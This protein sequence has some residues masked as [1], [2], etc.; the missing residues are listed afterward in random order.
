[1]GKKPEQPRGLDPKS[2][3][4]AMARM[5]LSIRMAANHFSNLFDG[6]NDPATDIQEEVSKFMRMPGG[7]V[8]QITAGVEYQTVLHMQALMFLLS[9]SIVNIALSSR[10]LHNAGA[11]LT[12]TQTDLAR[13]LATYVANLIEQMVTTAYAQHSAEKQLGDVLARKDDDA[14]SN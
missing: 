7:K 5:Q 3:I 13:G 9:E 4:E 14:A 12:L 6:M 2:S 11:N 1:M 8:M 10:A